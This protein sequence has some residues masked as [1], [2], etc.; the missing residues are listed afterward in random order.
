MICIAGMNDIDASVDLNLWVV[1]DALLTTH[2]TTL[3]AR[4]LGKTQ[5]TVSHALDRLRRALGDPLLVRV[6]RGLAPTPRATA[7]AGPLRAWLQAGIELARG[8]TPI[9]PAGLRTTFTVIATD[10]V[11]AIALP[12]L[13][14]TLRDRAPGVT[15]E[16]RTRA[17]AAERAVR[18]G[19]VDLFVGPF[20]R[21]LDG[22][23]HCRSASS[24]RTRRS[25]PRARSA[26]QRTS[27]AR[28]PSSFTPWSCGLGS[29]VDSRRATA[30]ASG[31][32]EPSRSRARRR[33]HR[34]SHP[35]RRAR[36][37]RT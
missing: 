24:S 20:V 9:E 33:V 16:V 37:P 8:N 13:V 36:R 32:C 4:Q 35:A 19:E 3:A 31:P 2:S 11:E 12:Q 7:L 18:D 34:R 6:G 5:S 28:R 29:A 26:R 30:A 23:W 14:A 21:E 27:Q 10:F 17:D 15:L 22:I 1:L 25:A